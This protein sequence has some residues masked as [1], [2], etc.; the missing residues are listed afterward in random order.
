[1]RNITK[2]HNGIDW[3]LLAVV[4]TIAS[5]GLVTLYT[6]DATEAALFDKQVLVLSIAGIVM[7]VLSYGNYRFLRKSWVVM[8]LYSVVVAMLAGLIIF[9]SVFSGAQSWFSVGGF[10]LQPAEF[11]KLALILVLAKYF[12]KRHVE[13]ASA[14]HLLVSGLYA[15]V[16][17]VLVARQPDFGSA[18]IIFLIWF[19]MVLLAGINWKQVA[20]LVLSGAVALVMMWFFVFSPY[21]QQRIIT[22]IQPSA[23]VQGT[24]YNAAQAEIAVG[25]G[26][27]LGKGVGYG[28]Q[29]RL[30]FLPQYQTDFIVAAFA[31]EWGFVGVITLLGLYGLVIVRLVQSGMHGE[32]NFEMLFAGGVA[33]YFMA[34]VVVHTGINIGVL[35]VTGITIPFM[36]YGG[37]HLLAEAIALGLVFGMRRYRRSIHRQGSQAELYTHS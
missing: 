22:Y 17:F 33:I 35:P 31:E 9:G 8:A 15:L 28:S 25:S 26:G 32:T 19:G 24:G 11:A 13:I 2:Q 29:S 3:L 21:Q 14:R 30:S 6:F 16:L 7:L 1:M 12:S 5:W 37:S 20:L 34:H 23:D 36:S 4:G 10:A 27:V 18:V